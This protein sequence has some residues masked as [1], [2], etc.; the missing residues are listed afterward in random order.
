VGGCG[1]GIEVDRGGGVGRGGGR[2]GGWEEVEA[3]QM[4]SAGGGMGGR[5]VGD[6]G[7]FGESG[8]GGWVVVC[9]R[10]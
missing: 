3:E 10:E 4:K 5:R 8:C 1:L 2:G 9:E 7:G 6:G